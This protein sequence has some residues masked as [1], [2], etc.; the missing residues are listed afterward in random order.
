MVKQSSSKKK[1][2]NFEESLSELEGLIERLEMGEQTLESSLKDFER[3]VELTR[4]CQTALQDAE[5]RVEQLIE[6]SGVEQLAI[7]N[8]ISDD[9]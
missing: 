8:A 7:F 5:Q 2:F 4:N 3:G 1:D 6:K 9:E